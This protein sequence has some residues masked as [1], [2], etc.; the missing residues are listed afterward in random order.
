MTVSGDWKTTLWGLL[1]PY[2]YDDQGRVAR[3]AHHRHFPLCSLSD[4]QIRL[5]ETLDQ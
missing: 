1:Y 5:V 3:F 2:L 4:T